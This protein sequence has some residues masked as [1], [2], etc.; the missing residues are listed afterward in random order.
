MRSTGRREGKRER[1]WVE[2]TAQLK[3]IKYKKYRRYRNIIQWLEWEVSSMSPAVSTLQSQLGTLFAKVCGTAFLDK[4]SLCVSF[5]IKW[6]TS[7]PQFALSVSHWHLKIGAVLFLLLAQCVLLVI[8]PHFQENSPFLQQQAQIN[9]SPKRCFWVWCFITTAEKWLIYMSIMGCILK[10]GKGQ[11]S[12]TQHIL[13]FILSS[14]NST[15]L[16]FQKNN[17]NDS[18]EDNVLIS[19]FSR[20]GTCNDLMRDAV[21]GSYIWM[22]GP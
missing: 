14:T 10:E 15:S 21:I 7:L 18:I 19:Y 12:Y 22:F 8:V 2:Y 6:L 5:V 17:F 13:L 4:R 3:A 16:K 1:K 11:T 20:Q 9:S